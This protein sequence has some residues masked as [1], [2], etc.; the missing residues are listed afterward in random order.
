VLTPILRYATESEARVCQGH[1]RVAQGSGEPRSSSHSSPTR[2]W[3]FTSKGMTGHNLIKPG[4]VLPTC[5][6]MHLRHFAALPWPAPPSDTGPSQRPS[7]EGGERSFAA[8]STDDHSAPNRTLQSRGILICKCL[9]TYSASPTVRSSRSSVSPLIERISDIKS[10]SS[11][12]RCAWAWSGPFSSSSAS[13]S[14]G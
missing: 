6:N 7:W 13:G 14:G 2:P 1:V 4:E 9:P 3:A 11:P 8:L 12:V 5:S 10:R